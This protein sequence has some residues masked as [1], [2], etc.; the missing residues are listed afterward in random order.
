MAKWDGRDLDGYLYGTAIVCLHNHRSP[1]GVHRTFQ[2]S[3]VP[4]SHSRKGRHLHGGKKKACSPIPGASGDEAGESLIL[5]D[6]VPNILSL[7][8][9]KMGCAFTVVIEDVERY[10]IASVKYLKRLRDLQL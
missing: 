8:G 9:R 4:I 10:L 1:R 5:I 3:G 6:F 7:P 2:G